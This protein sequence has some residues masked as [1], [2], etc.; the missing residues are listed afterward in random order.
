MPLHRHECESCG[1]HFRILVL[2]GQETDNAPTCPMC[3]S[4][5]TRHRLPRVAIQFKGS[6]YYKTDRAKKSRGEKDQRTEEKSTA[7]STGSS[8]PKDSTS[9]KDSKTAS[10]SK[11]HNGVK[12]SSA[13]S[14]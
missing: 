5:E 11:E 8:T 2:R 6:G 4:Q 3:G 12:K 7:D 1:H 14:E 13:S 10:T 9:S